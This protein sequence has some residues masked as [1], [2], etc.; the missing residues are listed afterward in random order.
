M[1]T[2]SVATEQ[3][4]FQA[5]RL[6]QRGDWVVCWPGQ[7]ND[8][9]AFI[10]FATILAKNHRVILC[11]LP[12]F[13]SN[14][15]LPYTHSINEHVYYAHQLLIK[16]GIKRCHWVGFAGGGVVGAALHL[17]M[18]T[19]LISLTLASTPMLSQSRIK[20][21]TMA[22]SSLLGG[23]RLGR[24]LLSSRVVREMGYANEAE[25]ALLIKYFQQTF[26]RA[27][28]KAVTH[29]RAIDGVSVRRTFDRLRT[30]Q[31]PMLILM[32]KHDGVILPRDQ[33]TVAEITRSEIVYLDCGHMTLTIEPENCA[34][35]FL[36]FVSRLEAR[37]PSANALAA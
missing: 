34:N 7:L 9:A 29:L 15:E 30:H 14:R 17:A 13:G 5:H 19:R 33:R 24:R 10:D 16:T 1:K 23:S 37:E 12:G 22:A 18:P 35:A 8:H 26:E 21:N 31:P 11:D 36:H 6:G 27:H 4:N 20:L 32:G 3:G 28:P 2:I 25:K